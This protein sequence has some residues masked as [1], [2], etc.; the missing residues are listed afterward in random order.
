MAREEIELI[1]ISITQVTSA[2]ER[3]GYALILN[4]SNCGGRIL[5]ETKYKKELLPLLR[6]YRKQVKQ[7][8][9]SPDKTSIILRFVNEQII[10]N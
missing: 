6:K 8:G 4:W 3:V 9:L 2:G 10:N 7:L 1:S 5:H